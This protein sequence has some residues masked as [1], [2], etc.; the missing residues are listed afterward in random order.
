MSNERSLS[1]T[2]LEAQRTARVMAFSAQGYSQ[3]EIGKLL[4][5]SQAT[6]KRYMDRV[7]KRIPAEDAKQWR[8]VQ[9]LRL[10]RLMEACQA[11]LTANHVVVSNGQIVQQY[12]KDDEGKP[13]WDPVY[14]PDGEQ[15]VN[16]KGKLRVE[17]RRV[18]LEDH[19]AVLEAVA[20]MRKLEVEIMKLIGTQV[21]VKQS[22]ELQHVNYVIEGVDM[23]KVIGAVRTGTPE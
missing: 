4:G 7:Q 12:V 9:L 18:P 15:L 6:V 8:Q 16:D 3:R 1:P 10:E 11:V 13:I 21:Q 23:D 17:Q 22:V 5:I 20:E 2:E 14:G 19:A